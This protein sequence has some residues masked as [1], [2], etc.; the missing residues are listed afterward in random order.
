MGIADL[1]GFGK[2]TKP[3][4]KIPGYVSAL[5]T[6]IEDENRENYPNFAR[7]QEILN[8]TRVTYKKLGD[9][10]SQGEYV[11]EALRIKED[12]EKRIDRLTEKVNKNKLEAKQESGTDYVE[13]NLEYLERKSRRNQAKTIYTECLE[14]FESITAYFKEERMKHGTSLE[15]VIGELRT[16]IS[17]LNKNYL[18]IYG[19]D[20]EIQEIRG[21]LLGKVRDLNDFIEE[22]K[23]RL[24]EKGLESKA[25]STLR[26]INESSKVIRP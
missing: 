4:F 2:K 21:K 24:K 14:S 25:Q 17:T 8:N 9:I 19:K 26:E 7:Y 1:F 15:S 12:L 11:K 20:K 22:N 10:I 6:K 23:E 18:N 16:A 5:R 3:P 13:S